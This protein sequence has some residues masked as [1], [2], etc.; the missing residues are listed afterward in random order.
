MTC[1]RKHFGV[2]A[3]K[4]IFGR[5][6]ASGHPVVLGTDNPSIYGKTLSDE[7]ALAC[8]TFDLTLAQVFSLARDAIAYTC[9]DAAEQETLRKEFDAKIDALKK[10]YHIAA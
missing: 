8:E 9:A 4:N 7:Y 1:H 6:R 5:L 10:K 2:P 3:A